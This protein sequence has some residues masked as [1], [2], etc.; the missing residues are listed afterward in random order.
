MKPQYNYQG[1]HAYFDDPLRSPELQNNRECRE[2][3]HRHLFRDLGD[4]F[5]QY[6]N[7]V[8]N[9]AF[10]DEYLALCKKY[11]KPYRLL[12][13]YSNWNAQIWSDPLPP[14]KLLGYEYCELPWELSCLLELAE[15]PLFE[16]YRAKLNA[17]G[18]FDTYEDA[19][20]F[21][22]LYSSLLKEDKVGDGDACLFVCAVYEVLT[23]E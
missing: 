8:D 17:D 2:I 15:N 20:D 13:V 19:A 4:G 3:E 16:Q 14:M 23:E 9:Q 11:N 6:L 7:F 22:V 18:L 21:G 12:F 1:V 5:S 10:L